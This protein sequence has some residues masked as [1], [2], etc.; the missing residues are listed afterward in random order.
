MSDARSTMGLA[1][2]T[3]SSGFVTLKKLN[4]RISA[5]CI[6]SLKLVRQLSSCHA[7]AFSSGTQSW[8]HTPRSI[9]LLMSAGRPKASRPMS[10]TPALAS[11]VTLRLGVPQRAEQ[12]HMAI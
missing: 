8:S 4:E 1:P 9:M 12:V 2:R 6:D 10:R 5:G 11:E 3:K 7:G